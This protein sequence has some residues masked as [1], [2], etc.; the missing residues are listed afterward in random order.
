MISLSHQ[1]PDDFDN[2]LA[3]ISPSSVLVLTDTNTQEHCLPI[4][5][6]MMS[7]EYKTITVPAGEANKNWDTAQQILSQMHGMQADRHSLMI[8]LG[9][10]MVTDLVGFC[11]SV[12]K[13][14]IACLH[15]P[16]TITAMCDAAI[17]GK[18]GINFES[19]KNQI[20]TFY[21]VEGVFIEPRFLQTLPEVEKNNGMVELIK[22]LFLMQKPAQSRAALLQNLEENLAQAADFKH[23][24]TEKDLR[25][26]AE[27]RFLNIGHTVGHALESIFPGL[28]HGEAV[29]LGLYYEH[30]FAGS[31]LQAQYF[32]TII[33]SEYSHLLKLQKPKMAELEAPMLHDKKTN[34][35]QLILPYLNDVYSWELL[36]TKA[37]ELTRKTVEIWLG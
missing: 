26:H 15:F 12:Y 37:K 21:P 17:G 1:I 34:S 9:G 6:A 23:K 5:D 2:L 13:R 28:S 30:A 35:T 7:L 27:R 22:T 8:G 33:K 29:L 10:G 36:P 18:N 16:T 3:R 14:G 31:V 24:L 4:W 32:K 25:D 11:A 20:G 19:T